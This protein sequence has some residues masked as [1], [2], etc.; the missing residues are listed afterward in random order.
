HY[1]F[2]LAAA[3]MAIGLVQYARTRRNLPEAAHHGANPLPRRSYAGFLA[4]AAAA[5]AV[6]VL[7]VALGLVTPGNLAPVMAW[8]AIL[9]A[10]AYFAVILSSRQVTAAERRRVFAFIPLFIASAAF[11]ALFQQQFTVVALY[12][13]QQLDRHLLGWEMPASWVQS[14]NPVFIIVFA[15]VFAALWTRLGPGQPGSPLKFALGLAVMGLAFLAFIPLSGGGASRTPLPA[16]AGIL[17]LF[18]MAELFLSPTGSSVS[19]KLA[20][21]A[22]QT[23]LVALYLLSISLGTTLA[24]I[25]AGYYDPTREVP[26][27]G[28]IGATA[29]VLGLALAAAVPSL[30]RLM[31]GIR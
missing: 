12:S 31:G 7:A 22:F 2:G 1:G 3:G 23:Q 15:G 21:K 14:I 26:Y 19:T 17:F 25:L 20:P 8:L 18:T 11:W 30:K 16:L 13:D 28:F 24:G 9:A 4:A 27:F 6:I 10:V 29:I 5:A